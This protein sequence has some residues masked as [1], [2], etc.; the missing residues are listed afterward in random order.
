MLF[1]LSYGQFSNLI[2]IVIV[3]SFVVEYPGFAKEGDKTLKSLGIKNGLRVQK[4]G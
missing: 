3:F 1:T 2:S 4:Y